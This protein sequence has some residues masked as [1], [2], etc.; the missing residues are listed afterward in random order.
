VPNVK[1]SDR[2]S[3]IV[4]LVAEAAGHDAR[5]ALAALGTYRHDDTL[6]GRVRSAVENRTDVDLRAAFAKAF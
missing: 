5:D 4:S 2:W 1:R 6:R 3:G